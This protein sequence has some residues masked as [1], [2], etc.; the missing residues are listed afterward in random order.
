LITTL[1]KCFQLISADRRWRWLLLIL[2]AVVSSGLEVT[3]AALVYAMIALVSDPAGEV[4]LPLVG[5]LRRLAGDVDDSTLLLAIAGALGL[6]FLVRAAAQVAI[7]YA[8]HRVANREGARL[9]NR[10]TAGYLALPYAFHLQRN[11]ADLIRNVNSAVTKVVGRAFMP[12]IQVFADIVVVVGLLTVMAL[13]SPLATTVA[14]VVVG[15]AAVLLLLVVQP[16]LKRLGRVS[17]QMA[18]TTLQA[19]Q[20]PLHGLRDVK[21]LGREAA[22]AHEYAVNRDRLARAQYLHGTALGLPRHVMETALVVFILVFFAY[23][24]ITDTANEQVLS[25]MGL[26]AYTGLRLQPSLAHIVRGLNSLKFASAA[27]DEVHSE[28]QLI[29]GLHPPDP[30]PARPFLSR[31]ELER[32]TFRYEGTE[33]DV[34]SDVDL[35]IER[36]ET[37]GICGTTG[38]GKTTLVDLITGLLEPTAGRILIDGRELAEDVRGWQRNLAV[39]PQMV[40]LIDDTL[41]RNIA[42]G[43][44]DSEVDDEAVSEA[45][46]LAQLDEFIAGLPRGLDTTVGERGVRISGGQRQ[47]IAIARALYR[48]VSVLVFDE[49]TS[50]LDNTTEAQLMQALERLQG[51]HTI[52]LVAHRLSTVRNCD[53]V[54]YTVRGRIEGLGTY[55]EL[56]AYHPGF[57]SLAANA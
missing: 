35:R 41:R 46:K 3:G 10:L 51:D 48:K 30:Q 27:V 15:G 6:F 14:V 28:L 13:V 44:P 40:F 47:R 38:S 33:E 23:T 20:Q 55:D 53:K 21:L 56:L 29:K 9:A 1:G 22:F 8:Q 16:R 25:T 24:V 45:V 2:L 42:L 4:D 32:V 39:V 36:G 26:F 43:I 34:L 52:I 37:V 11:T 50:A 57:R 18:K 17:H 5:D 49:G 19:L 12:I 31:I 54:V 7:S